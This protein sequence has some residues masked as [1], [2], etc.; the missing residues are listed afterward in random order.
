MAAMLRDTSETALAAAIDANQAAQFGLLAACM[1]GETH[2]EPDAL[3]FAT[4]SDYALFNGVMRAR[5]P[6][7]RAAERIAALLAPFRGRGLPMTWHVGSSSEPAELGVQ[8]QRRGLWRELGEPGMAAELSRLPEERHWVAGFR[9]VPVRDDATFR[10]WLEVMAS[11]FE[12]PAV[13]RDGIG[14]ACR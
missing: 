13:A 7:E 1:G 10:V 3:W 12:M 5:L 4:G 6:A 9:L 14:V 8:L 2:D 11:G